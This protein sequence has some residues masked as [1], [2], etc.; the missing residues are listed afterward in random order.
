MAWFHSQKIPKDPQEKLLD[1]IDRFSK[2]VE[3]KINTQKSTKYMKS[4]TLVIFVEI[5]I[6]QE[7]DI[8]LSW[9]WLKCKRLEKTRL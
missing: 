2:A 9:E 7:S 6:K 8:I 1:L 3:Y 5:Q 4:P